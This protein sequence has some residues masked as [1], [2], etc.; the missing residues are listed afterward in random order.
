MAKPSL[1]LL[2][3]TTWF[4]KRAKESGIPNISL[5]PMPPTVTVIF[6]FQWALFKPPPRLN[7]LF[8]SAMG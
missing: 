6:T 4:Q 3:R 5:G 8:P 1:M 2:K 7:S